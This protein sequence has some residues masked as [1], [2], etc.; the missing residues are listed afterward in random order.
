MNVRP[1]AEVIERKDHED[2]SSTGDTSSKGYRTH[3]ISQ[4]ENLVH[5]V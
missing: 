2:N 4:L 1:G 3:I 5:S